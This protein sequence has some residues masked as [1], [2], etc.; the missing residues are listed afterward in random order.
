M[1]LFV[2]TCSAKH[3]GLCII[4]TLLISVYLF[5][6]SPKIDNNEDEYEYIVYEVDKGELIRR[7]SPIDW[8]FNTPK[9]Y[10]ESSLHK[11]SEHI[12]TTE[13]KSVPGM[14]ENGM[15]FT[16]INESD[17]RVQESLKKNGYNL[18]A[19]EMM[20]LHR[21]IPDYRCDECKSLTYPSKLPTASVIFIF[22]NEPWSLLLRSV[23]SVIDR[24]PCELIEEIILV[25]DDSDLKVLKRP[26]EDYIELLPVPVK[27]IRTKKRE[28]LI[29][30]RL[31][32]AKEAKVTFF[33][34]LSRKTV[35]NCYF[36][37]VKL[38]HIIGIHRV[39]F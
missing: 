33:H 17:P 5:T 7:K 16:R 4:T 32:G 12:Q 11:W 9:Y 3:L 35:K 39:A 18:L 15:A 23:W 1:Y 31:F 8:K 25:D 26:L 34:L 36:I 22:H 14:G 30:A 37:T 29:R 38:T 6:K 2:I 24:S 19:T 21:S 28:G 27:L 13:E 20:S 10:N